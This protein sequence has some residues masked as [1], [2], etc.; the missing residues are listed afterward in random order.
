MPPFLA[1]STP[2][3]LLQGNLHFHLS[4]HNEC[5]SNSS[6]VAHRETPLGDWG[7]LHLLNR[8]PTLEY[9][10]RIGRALQSKDGL[11]SHPRLDWVLAMSFPVPSNEPDRMR[12]LQPL[13]PSARRRT[14]KP[15]LIVHVELPIFRTQG[16]LIRRKA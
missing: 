5:G 11:D 1:V 12:T 16:K 6:E 15:A 4:E 9:V 13:Q 14:H 8:K 3:K 7:N 2:T 10:G